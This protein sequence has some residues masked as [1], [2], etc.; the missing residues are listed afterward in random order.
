MKYKLGFIGAGNMGGAL[1]SAALKT[2]PAQNIAVSEKN[3]VLSDKIRSEYGCAPESAVT[4]AKECE[5]IF[6]GVKPQIMPIV[7]SD[8]KD[9][10]ASCETPFTVVTMA[11]GVSIEKLRGYI[12]GE[13]P[14]IRIMPNTPVKVGEGMVLYTCSENVTDSALNEFLSVMAEAGR[15]DRLS[16]NL[17]D[18]GCAISGCGP[19][20]AY[21]FI[22][23]LADGAVTCGLPRDKAISYAA[24]TLLGS[25][26]MVL[27][28]GEHPELLKDNVCSPGGSTIAGVRELEAHGFRGAALDAVIAAYD[29]TVELGK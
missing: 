24:Q 3:P 2:T 11:A 13:H 20:F 12:G 16:E 23:A 9:A 25:A 22:E 18:A 29:R 7:C 21:M 19:A 5:F 14:V 10:L 28:T 17:I 1:L 15:F 6:L 26:K 4:V 27:E 8:I